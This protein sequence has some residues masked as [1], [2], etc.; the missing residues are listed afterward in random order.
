MQRKGYSCLGMICL[1]LRF[2]WAHPDF[3]LP[4][5]A[6]CTIAHGSR[7]KKLHKDLAYYTHHGAEYYFYCSPHPRMFFE[8]P[9]RTE[10]S[11]PWSHPVAARYTRGTRLLIAKLELPIDESDVYWCSQV[12]L[13]K[14]ILLQAR[15]CGYG[16]GHVG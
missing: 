2:M 3:S 12:D 11:E 9:M 4:Q 1:P 7:R 16:C 13:L 15:G 10:T 14:K 5:Q 8:A 6:P